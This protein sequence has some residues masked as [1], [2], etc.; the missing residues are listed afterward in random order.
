MRAAG[1]VGEPCSE[2]KHGILEPLQRNEPNSNDKP[3]SPNPSIGHMFVHC[4]CQGVHRKT[5]QPKTPI[6]EIVRSRASKRMRLAR[7]RAEVTG[8]MYSGRAD[9]DPKYSCGQQGQLPMFFCATPKQRSASS[10][11]K[12]HEAVRQQ[13]PPLQ[14][15]TS[16]MFVCDLIPVAPQRKG[17]WGRP[18]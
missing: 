12:K 9:K 6:G 1:D 11:R 13:L 17:S 16:H 15:L 5:N 14:L 3:T 8:I 10:K 7:Y 2:A 4:P 18:H